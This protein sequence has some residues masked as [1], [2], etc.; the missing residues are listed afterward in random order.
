[1]K[2]SNSREDLKTKIIQNFAH[3]EEIHQI[4]LFGRE[5]DRLTDDYS[6]IDMVVCSNDLARTQ[7]K[8]R[9]LFNNISPIVNTWLIESKSTSLAEM[10]I[11]RDYSPYQK[12]DFSIVA[13]IEEKAEFG[14]FT[15]VYE[16][17]GQVGSGLSQLEVKEIQKDV[18]YKLD[19]VLFSIVRFTKCLFRNDP[20]MYRRWKSISDVALAMLYEKYFGWVEEN[21]QKLRANEAKR[22]Y[23]KLESEDKGILAEVFPTTG[24]LNVALSYQAS[25][26]LIVELS[27]QKARHLRLTVNDAFAEHMQEFLASEV[28]RFLIGE[29]PNKAL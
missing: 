19:E 26:N 6:D 11:L 28:E 27:K 22:L 7:E 21:R 14:P 15:M 12:I 10:L 16:S 3:Q 8:Y 4:F 24:N 20:D 9:K 5:V 29:R 18:T 1:M 2:I 13:D 25:I 23:A 17:N